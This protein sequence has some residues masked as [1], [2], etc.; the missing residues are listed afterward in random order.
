MIVKSIKFLSDYK[1]F[2][3]GQEFLFTSAENKHLSTQNI[4]FSVLVGRNG[5]GK[6]TLMSLIPTLFHHIERYNG[7]IAANFELKYSLRN[8]SVT[9]KHFDNVI[10][11]TVPNRFNNTQLVPKRNPHSNDFSMIN[12]EKPF[13]EYNLFH[14]YTP[15]S[16]VTS[17]FSLHGEY[18]SSRPNNY[19]GHQ[20]VSDQSITNIYGNNHWQMGSISRG[21]LRF[22]RL[23]F[24]SENEIKNLLNLFDLE[25]TNRVEHKYWGAESEW[26]NVNKTWLKKHDVEIQMEEA[27]L[28]DIEFKRD[29]RTITLSNMSS[30]EKMLL[31][32]AISVLNSIE[33]DSIV[34]IEEPELHL[35]QVWNR[36]L[37]TFFQILFKD[38]NTH[39]IIATHDYSII[40]SVPQ[41]NLIPLHYGKRKSIKENTFLASYDE[42][43]SVLY[44]DKFK[45]NKIEEDFL[46]TISLKDLET[47]KTDYK[48]LGNSV[49]KYLVFRE[50]KSRS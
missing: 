28:N 39:L 6:T 32:R 23:F 11:V 36:Q 40:N 33:N 50:I 10:Y 1:Q 9:I 29:N 27:Y 7:K 19:K 44:G 42:L 21:I 17:T 22:I 15:L 13:I 37:I 16:I 12:K 8:T 46:E 43:F 48:R 41:T 26:K 25:F 35:D 30:G 5:S 47:L 14:E 2:T 4:D 45:S 3:E 18:P 34:I 49:F 38:Y 31:L 24:E 20:L